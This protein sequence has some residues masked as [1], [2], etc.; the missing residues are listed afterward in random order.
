VRLELGRL[1]VTLGR[2][3]EAVAE[4]EA[5]RALAPDE[6]FAIDA[7]VALA[8]ARSDAGDPA[9]ARA[10]LEELQALPAVAADPVA[11]ARVRVR[12]RALAQPP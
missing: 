7:A 12:L 6:A 10:L 4:L 1:L 11:A 5:A 8:D 3:D 2:P 9:G